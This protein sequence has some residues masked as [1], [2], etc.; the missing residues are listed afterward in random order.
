MGA[1]RAE[2]D[3][4]SPSQ[5]FASSICQPARSSTRAVRRKTESLLHASYPLP[6]VPIGHCGY[7]SAPDLLQREAGLDNPSLSVPVASCSHTASAAVFLHLAPLRRTASSSTFCY[8]AFV[9]AQQLHSLRLKL[10]PHDPRY[11][12]LPRLTFH[13]QYTATLALGLFPVRVSS[14]PWAL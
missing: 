6:D 7:R 1:I 10:I 3:T 11:C 8:R 12:A 4:S 13:L 9:P 5:P 2:K 14:R